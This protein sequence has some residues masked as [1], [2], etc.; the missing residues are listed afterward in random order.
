VRVAEGAVDALLAH[1][2]TVGEPLARRYRDQQGVISGADRVTAQNRLLLGP[3][4]ESIPV[5]TGIFCL[6]SQE[7]AALDL[8]EAER[9]LLKPYYKHAHV[10][11]YQV[12][13][14]APDATHW[15]LYVTADTDLTA[16]PGIRR[17]LERFRP[18][19][20]RKRECVEGKL[21]WY[22]LHW[23]RTESLL[24]GES[25]V[26][27][28]RSPFNAF[29]WAEPGW[30]EHSDLTILVPRQP[31]PR[32][33]TLIDLAVLNSSLLDFWMA[34]RG[35]LKGVI[36]EYFATPLRAMPLPPTSADP[37]L[38]AQVERLLQRQAQRLAGPLPKKSRLDASMIQASSPA[39]YNEQ[40]ALNHAI[41][42]LFRLSPDWIAR[43]DAWT[44]TSH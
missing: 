2:Q 11:P 18:I 30:Y 8:S 12:A 5:G 43:V 26:T 34:H 44:L 22:S 20:E 29:A 41:Y 28:R 40:T 10:F 42:Q 32:P 27:S 37:A 6:S 19:L 3:A 33:Q 7:V 13:W 35:K 24:A 4:G 31:Q 39:L 9:A 17:H 25:L 21:P 38:A 16:Y 15:L 36:R 23:P 1:L 14:P